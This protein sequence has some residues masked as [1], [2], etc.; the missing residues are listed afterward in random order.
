MVTTRP[1][2]IFLDANVVIRA[3]KPPARPLMPRVA[4]LVAAGY[5]KVITTDLTKTEIAKKHAS[6]DFEV[7]DG[8]AR[9]RA[10]DLAAEILGIKLPEISPA[11]LHRILLERHQASV[12]KMFKSLQAETSLD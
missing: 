12:E 4:D 1:R 3:G 2:K 11:D 8:L 9:R 5:V 6:N 10:R 7:L